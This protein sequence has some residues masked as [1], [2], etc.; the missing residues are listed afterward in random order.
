[1]ADKKRKGSADK[2]SRDSGRGG[3]NVKPAG[4][5]RKPK[6]RRSDEANGPPEQ[7][8]SAVTVPL[9]SPS[10]SASGGA[11]VPLEDP[12]NQESSEN[13]GVPR[14]ENPDGPQG[15]PAAEAAPS[16]QPV[17]DAEDAPQ[18][19][20]R[21]IEFAPSEAV[22]EEASEAGLKAE[23]D[24]EPPTE[25]VSSPQVEALDFNVIRRFEA[26]R[27][28]HE[29]TQ[30]ELRLRWLVEQGAAAREGDLQ[31]RVAEQD[32]ESSFFERT[33]HLG[34]SIA[35]IPTQLTLGSADAMRNAGV[36]GDSSDR[37]TTESMAN[38]PSTVAG[39]AAR[40]FST[41]AVDTGIQLVGGVLGG[42]EAAGDFM[43]EMIP[44]G[45]LVID[46]DGVRIVPIEDPKTDR[47][48]SE[49]PQPMTLPG[50][51]ARS[52]GQ[53]LVIYLPAAKLLG[54]SRAVTAAG[55]A[56][57][58]VTA[59][60][61]AD[62]LSSDGSERLANFLSNVPEAIEPVVEYLKSDEE[63]SEALN[64][65]KNSLE[66]VFPT[67][68]LSPFV[69]LVR[70][71]KASAGTGV[72]EDVVRRIAQQRAGDDALASLVDLDSP[73]VE[74]EH[75]DP[76]AAASF[77]KSG[78]LPFTG[79]PAKVNLA[80]V[81]EP[82]DV[83][84]VI[85]E[86]G[87][88][89]DARLVVNPQDL[90]QLRDALPFIGKDLERVAEAAKDGRLSAKQVKALRRNA[91]GL[92]QI[93]KLAKETGRTSDDIFGLLVRGNF[94]V[95]E[96]AAMRL[97]LESSNLKIRGLAGA[98][99]SGKG[100]DVQGFVLMRQIAYHAAL[101]DQLNPGRSRVGRRLRDFRIVADTKDGRRRAVQ[102][103][104][105]SPAGQSLG[106]VS[107]AFSALTSVEQV[108]AFIGAAANAKSRLDVLD[109]FVGAKVSAG[110]VVLERLASFL[111]ATSNPIVTTLAREYLS[112]NGEPSLGR[113]PEAQVRGMTRVLN[114][115]LLL[116]WT[117][118]QERASNSNQGFIDLSN[119]DAPLTERL[120]IR[121]GTEERVFSLISTYLAGTD[122]SFSE[123]QGEY[124][125][126][127]QQRSARH[128]AGPGFSESAALVE[129][130]PNAA[131]SNVPDEGGGAVGSGTT[132]LAGERP[133]GTGFYAAVQRSQSSA[134][135]GAYLM[136][137]G[138]AGGT[139]DAALAS[140]E[141]G[142]L[143]TLIV[144]DLAAQ[145]RVTGGGPA[146][147]GLR[148]SLSQDGWQ[149]YSIK[150]GDAWV[151]YG[152]DSL[153]GGLIAAAADGY[154]I[155]GQLEDEDAQDL[156]VL[157]SGS[158]GQR[159]GGS[160]WMDSFAAFT[161]AG[162]LDFDAMSPGEQR[163][164]L[165]ELERASQ[166]MPA[167]QDPVLRDT[168]DML[169][170]VRNGAPGYSDALPPSRNIWGEPV[171]FRGFQ[172]RAAVSPFEIGSRQAAPLDQEMQRLGFE[173]NMPGETLTVNGV[174][175]TLTPQE[176][177]RLVVLA[178]NEAKDPES[179]VG[180]RDALSALIETEAYK[181]ESDGPSGGRAWLVREVIQQYQAL[182]RAQ[183]IA[184]RERLQ[185]ALQDEARRLNEAAGQEDAVEPSRQEGHPLFPR[186]QLLLA[187]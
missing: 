1:M 108:N 175:V 118:R 165:G 166:R 55:R 174:N 155:V 6:T 131:N 83:R 79:S 90:S 32:E 138:A 39:A 9:E 129:G 164:L 117:L 54:V 142:G 89:L 23:S 113:P 134:L 143:L 145:G 47:A 106:I 30:D 130:M 167:V 40:V 49:I 101:L 186:Q 95:G 163:S 122:S 56:A 35:E 179:G 10:E 149:P 84:K 92:E 181:K 41:A 152:Q 136:G 62:A 57:R 141:L 96:I 70:T 81:A 60:G 52:V 93:V 74:L 68:L 123:R 44:L 144:W 126:V 65:F 22:L 183:L 3:P 153:L 69:L 137:L 115:V 13:V 182:A 162:T 140:L 104:L 53:Y 2:A 100:T 19:A 151:P 71:L 180:L 61:I 147:A 158:F 168:R 87:K 91:Q 111:M 12:T 42:I 20:L 103:W 28:N 51:I 11:T 72:A 85:A 172:N 105:A 133:F 88:V 17:E 176:H 31:R 73:L 63:D 161:A 124:V 120:F 33:E 59:G 36:I 38:Q 127:F 66:G 125:A 139:R 97:L 76:K 86:T 26:D 154:D 157:L 99:A 67:L 135:R 173:P 80:R 121:R 146:D 82:Q 21:G 156:F 16:S 77:L 43:E 116:S 8:P 170:V 150:V 25:S 98:V 27:W 37:I 58:E 128:G 107:K 5:A 4:S 148:A 132:G 112:G 15:V 110:D 24:D 184:E 177:D 159:L 48:T 50:R 119:T 109:A 187:L 114:E 64:R 18:D 178:G 7:S 171:L 94:T 14:V 46:R 169:G 160:A 185:R 34:R 45:R 75:L 102:E 78:R 29:S